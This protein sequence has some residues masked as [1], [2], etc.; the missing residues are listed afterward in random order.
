MLDRRLITSLHVQTMRRAQLH[1]EHEPHV[2]FQASTIAA[3]VEGAYEGDVSFAELAEHGDFGI[4]TLNSLDGE[5]IALDGRFH[6]ADADGHAAEVDAGE[7]TPFA[8][9]AWFEPSLDF[10]LMECLD[11]DALLAEVDRRVPPGTES[12]A[13]RVDGDFESMRARSIPRQSPPY[14]P[15][16]EV[17][18]DQH[19][20]ELGAISGTMVGFRF[21]DYSEG[22][23]V[24]GYH[25][26]FISADRTRGGHVLGC[27]SAG[28]RV[29]VDF[30]NDL[31]VELPPGV[32]LAGA[33]VSE[34][35]SA[36]LQRAQNRG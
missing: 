32:D 24:S 14:R 17:L 15:L 22:L 29:R 13:I 33:E 16:I 35:T 3:M 34:S 4:G 31:H 21:P 18:A 5:M 2:L 30:S 20:F 27:R 7:L 11:R 23:E 1:P 28:V 26:H 9:M 19:V 36:A 6:R 8:V 10:G 25:F 12:C